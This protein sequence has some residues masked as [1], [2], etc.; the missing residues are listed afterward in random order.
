M[1]ML[2]GR[3]G[4]GIAG[5]LRPPHCCSGPWILARHRPPKRA[6]GDKGCH[7]T[8]WIKIVIF[9][10]E[11][12]TAAAVAPNY[13]CRHADRSGPVDGL[14]EPEIGAVLGL[15]DRVQIE[16]QVAA[17]RSLMGRGRGPGGPPGGHFGLVY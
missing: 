3:S 13:A 10:E 7:V 1:A 12:A 17:A 6:W 11:G 5:A 4:T 8:I 14:Q 16:F 15:G 2:K 9:Y